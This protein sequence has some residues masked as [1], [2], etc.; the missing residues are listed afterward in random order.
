MS[1]VQVGIPITDRFNALEREQGVLSRS[2]LVLQNECSE[3]RQYIVA[4]QHAHQKSAEYISALVQAVKELSEK[5]REV[6]TPEGGQSDD[7]G[8]PSGEENPETVPNA[9]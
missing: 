7:Q 9:G 6:V 5:I 2:I 4:L 3:Q 1:E 8:A